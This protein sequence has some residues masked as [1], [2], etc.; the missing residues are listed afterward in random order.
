[1]RILLACFRSSLLHQA[2]TAQGHFVVSC[3]VQL[4]IKKQ[5]H[6]Q[7]DVLNIVNNDWDMIIACP[8]CTYLSRAQIHYCIKSPER[9]KR[10]L[11]AVLFFRK[12]MESNCALIACENPPGYLSTLY[13]PWDALTQPYYFGDPYFKELCFWLKGLPPLLSTCINPKRKSTVNLGGG[14]MSKIDSSNARSNWDNYPNFINAI[15][16]QWGTL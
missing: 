2:L 12:I 14:S 13:R 1:M 4:S 3:D 8:P 10:S 7:T 11:E 9:Y 15:V 6:L 16:A 5:R